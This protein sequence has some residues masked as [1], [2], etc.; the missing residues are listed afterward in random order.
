MIP[1]GSSRPPDDV[2]EELS[3][4]RHRRQTESRLVAGGF[5]LLALVGGGLLWLF[6]SWITAAIAIGVIVLC[7]I[8]FGG[9]FA[10]L[11][12]LERWANG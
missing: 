1:A 7:L 6:Y 4:I 9:L 8:L 11:R 3:K 5:V 12:L 2:I 10:F